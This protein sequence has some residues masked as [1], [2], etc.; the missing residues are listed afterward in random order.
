M[1]EMDEGLCYYYFVRGDSQWWSLFLQS[2]QR[3]EIRGFLFSLLFIIVIEALNRLLDK[4]RDEELLK[5]IVVGRGGSQVEV[6]YLFFVDDTLI[7]CQPD[8]NIILNLY[9][10]FCMD[11]YKDVRTW[12]P[13]IE[14]FER[15]LAGWRMNLLSKG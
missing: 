1:E 7:F 3:F 2:L 9:A 8:E 10:F 6:S 5:G 14:L 11:K 13:I 12:D 4:T 15:R